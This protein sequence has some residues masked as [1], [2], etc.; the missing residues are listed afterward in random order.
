VTSIEIAAATDRG[1]RLKAPKIP[2][3]QFQP[4]HDRIEINDMLV[5]VERVVAVKECVFHSKQATSNDPGRRPE[6]RSKQTPEI[7][8]NRPLVTIWPPAEI[9]EPP[10]SP[11]QLAS[12]A[13]ETDHGS[14]PRCP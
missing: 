7:Q 8:A 14:R 2:S 11:Q 3:R 12:V 4:R 6:M 1:C 5:A 9:R 10:I 13:S